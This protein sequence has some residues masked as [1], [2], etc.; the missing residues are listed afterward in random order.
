MDVC[1]EDHWEAREKLTKDNFMNLKRFI[2]NKFPNYNE[3]D[4]KE[5][6]ERKKMEIGDLFKIFKDNRLVGNEIEE[7]KEME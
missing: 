1:I 4:Q 6:D 3:L 2:Q 5:E 7:E